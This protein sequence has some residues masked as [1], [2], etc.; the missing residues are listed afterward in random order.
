M[1]MFGRQEEESDYRSVTSMQQPSDSSAIKIRLDSDPIKRRVE[2]YLRG[3]QEVRQQNPETGEW[4]IEVIEIGE[5]KANSMGIQQILSTLEMT[6]NSQ[7]VQ[8]YF[9]RDEYHKILEEMHE[10]LAIDLWINMYKYGINEE[11]YDGIVSNIMRF[12]RLFLSR[13]IDNTE[14]KSYQGWM[15]THERVN[16][17]EKKKGWGVNFGL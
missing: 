3:M 9:E 11:E 15:Q 17:E 2:I 4:E 14:R 5:P 12:V 6:I 13:T 10:D 16:N 7:T 1:K 8:G